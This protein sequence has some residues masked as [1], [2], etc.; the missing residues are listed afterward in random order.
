MRYCRNGA[1]SVAALILLAA[2]D[3]TPDPA[4]R[5]VRKEPVVVYAAFKDDAHLRTLFARYTDETG[6]LVI[7]R[8]GDT[9]VIVDDVI[10]N[11]I[12]PPADV[13]VT[14]S[15]TDAW[16]AAEEG[17]LRP[18]PSDALQ[19]TPAWSRDP[20]NLWAGFGH[21]I[22]VIARGDGATEFGDS[23]RYSDLAD[24]QFGRE[25]CL[26]SS[27]NAINQAIVAMLI[28]ELGVRP[29]ENVVRGWIKNL[30]LPVFDSDDQVLDAIAGS[31][32]KIGIVSSDA[33]AGFDVPVSIPSP[34]IADIDALGIGRHA[35]N[36]AGAAELVKWLMTT[37]P[38]AQFDGHER[39]IQHNVGLVAWYQDDV[40]KLAERA[41]YP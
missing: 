40:I 32:C 18:I 36:S 28:H 10:E 37:L 22:A 12:S 13:L 34:A 24:P 21:R 19:E 11:H 23:V 38:A 29:A 7:V 5:A 26:S 35:R 20:D 4:T 17:A 2:C 30:A 25:L 39:V 6:V 15:V 33:T 3:Q 14:R 16:R 8:G 1:L 41:R 9:D 31:Q 27:T